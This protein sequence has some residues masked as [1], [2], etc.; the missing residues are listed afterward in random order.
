[1]PK[2]SVV[3]VISVACCLF[4]CSATAQEDSSVRQCPPENPPRIL[5]ASSIDSDGQLVLVSY[6]SIFIG[7]TGESY[8]ERLTTSVSL[9]DV[10]ILTTDG[11]EVTLQAARERVAERDTPILVTSSGTQLPKF[12]ARMFAPET[13]L[14]VFPAQAPQWRE[15]ESPGAPVQR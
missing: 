10:K 2:S 4:P 14:F 15:I 6:H 9:E 3:M 5:V 12:Y 11:R 13:L 1:M 7:F 8:N